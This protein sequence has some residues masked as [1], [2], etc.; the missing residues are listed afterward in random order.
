MKI[1]VIASLAYW[2]IN[3]RGR[4]IAAMIGNGH[5][6]IVCA[7]GHDPEI[8]AKLA[9]MGA[10]YLP[11]AMARAGMNPFADMGTLS[12]LNGCFRKNRPDAVV[13]FKQYPIIYGGT[14]ES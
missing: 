12:W 6:V 3:F 11:M 5:E 9:A 14:G 4:L 13:A 1:I 7:P 2:V 8:E 10:P